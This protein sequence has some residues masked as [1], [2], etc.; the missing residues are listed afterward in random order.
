MASKRKNSFNSDFEKIDG[1]K[2]SRK[3][4]RERSD[5]TLCMTFVSSCRLAKTEEGL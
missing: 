3:G 2:R 1:V 4:C 5:V